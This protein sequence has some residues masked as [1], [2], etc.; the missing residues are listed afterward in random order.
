MS[1]STTAYLVGI[2]GLSG[3]EINAYLVLD[4]KPIKQDTKLKTL[5]KYVRQH[6]RGWKKR[7]ELADLL[8]AMGRLVEAV[9]EYRQV[10]SRQPQLIEVW[11][12]LGKILQMMARE[13]EAIEA[14]KSAMTLTGNPATRQHLTGLIES[15]RQCDRCAAIAFESAANLEADNPAHWLALGQTQLRIENPAA[16]LRAFDAILLQGPEDSIALIYSY[17]ALMALGRF[18][19]AR[20]R[21]NRALELAPEDFRALKRVADYRCGMGLV[22]GQE[23]KQTKQLINRALRQTANAPSALESLAYYHVFRGQWKKGVALLQK[24]AAGHPNNPGAW[25]SLARCLFHV[26]ENRKA[27]EAI[28]R[29]QNLY[30]GD[31]EIYRLACEI[32]PEAGKLQELEPLVEEMLERFPQR[33]SVWAAAGRVLVQHYKDIERGLEVAATGPKLQAQVAD[34]WFW[35]GRILALGNKHQEGVEALE[36]GWQQLQSSGG[37]PLPAALWLGE[38]YRTLG[39]LA[40]SQQ[41]WEEAARQA[42]ELME[43]N[44]ALAGYWQGKALE[45]FGDRTGAARAYRS[46]PSHQLLYPLG[47][48]V[49]EALKRL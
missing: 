40:K 4:E 16:A 49:K 45:A 7:K 36:Q 5:S 11:L 35:Y 26:G 28:L 1:R 34:A 8:R 23:G 30:R 18:R 38:S 19:E 15:C 42:A 29:A 39:D 12:Q 47:L 21:V 43:F 14:Y 32:L 24:F 31:C 41:W 13:A 37:C 20:E 48:E 25:Y 46:A 33:W 10:L 44:P 3:L 22:Y 6:P 27:A 2:D 17:D 9:G